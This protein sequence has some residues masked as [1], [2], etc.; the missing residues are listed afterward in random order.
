[1][2]K[3]IWHS[4]LR[5]GVDTALLQWISE[6]AVRAYTTA[7]CRQCSIVLQP[8]SDRIDYTVV[9]FMTHGCSRKLQKHCTSARWVWFNVR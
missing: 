3:K 2:A 5:H 8:R 1:M 6:Y 9:C 4:F 7:E